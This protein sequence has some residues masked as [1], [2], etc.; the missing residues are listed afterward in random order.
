MQKLTKLL[1]VGLSFALVA[2]GSMCALAQEIED[3]TPSPPSIGADVPVTY[4]G[5]PPSS[6]E[7]ELVGPVQLLRSGEIDLEAGTI[8]LPLYQGKM[9]E[10]GENV[11][12]VL[13][14]TTDEVNAEAL[15]LNLSSKLD[16]ADTC[17]ALRLGRQEFDGSIW[18]HDAGMKLRRIER[19]SGLYRRILGNLTA[20]G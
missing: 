7:P 9:F 16:Y 1:M 4:F 11:W 17:R 18:K 6:V 20:A 15:G 10:T 13:T 12:Y 5:P 8:T 2:A 3:V 19:F 14:D